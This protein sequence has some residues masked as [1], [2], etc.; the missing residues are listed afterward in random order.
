[1]E[2]PISPLFVF[3]SP[4]IDPMNLR[5]L[6]SRLQTLKVAILRLMAHG[7]VSKMRKKEGKLLFMKD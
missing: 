3:F 1:M 4:K 5:R 6:T 7:K 2:Y